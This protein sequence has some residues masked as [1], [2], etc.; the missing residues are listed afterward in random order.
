MLTTRCRRTSDQLRRPAHQKRDV[1]ND[2]LCCIPE[3]SK[4]TVHVVSVAK[5]GHFSFNAEQRAEHRVLPP[6]SKVPALR[7][8][9]LGRKTSS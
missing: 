3:I 7:T 2:H 6:A 1:R 4:I 5:V 9:N 8:E